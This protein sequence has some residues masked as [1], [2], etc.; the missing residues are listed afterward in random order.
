ME[1][2]VTPENVF[3]ISL[4]DLQIEAKEGIGRELTEEEVLIAKKGLENGLLTSI[5]IVYSTIF[6]EMLK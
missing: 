4:N 3:V 1:H 2:H 5:D 6:N